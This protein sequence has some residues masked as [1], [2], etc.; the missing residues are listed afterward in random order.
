MP[1]IVTI[2]T[3]EPKNVIVTFSKSEPLFEIATILV[4]ESFAT[5]RKNESRIKIATTVKSELCNMIATLYLNEPYI[6]IVT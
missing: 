2:D 3:S 1:Y 4:C 5:M 6:R